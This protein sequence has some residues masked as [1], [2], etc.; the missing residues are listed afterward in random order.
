MEDYY[1]VTESDI[2]DGL[3]L[4]TYNVKDI[5]D[6]SDNLTINLSALRTVVPKNKYSLY[7]V[8]EA[9]STISGRD[10][11]NEY[12]RLEK[13]FSSTRIFKPSH[14]SG[15]YEFT[16]VLLPIAAHNYYKKKN[17]KYDPEVKEL[18]SDN[19]I[20]KYI[21]YPLFKAKVYGHDDI[22]EAYKKYRRGIINGF[23]ECLNNV[24]D[25]YLLSS[26]NNVIGKSSMRLNL[27]VTG[28]EHNLIN[29][30]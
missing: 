4:S 22:I 19:N 13:Y 6:F 1:L 8:A 17:Q 28:A 14:K 15:E 23:K 25:D 16:D 7:D 12:K 21:Y 5:P 26:I 2:N 27:A 3:D 29:Q 30:I 20:F 18:L 10:K 24:N 11:E 9:Y